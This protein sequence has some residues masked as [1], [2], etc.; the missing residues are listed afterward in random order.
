MYGTPH[1]QAMKTSRAVKDLDVGAAKMRKTKSFGAALIESAY[2]AV[3]IAKGGAKPAR[4]Y[5][6][7]RADARRP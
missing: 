7:P 4:A 2:E 3:A 5:V 1:V 6:P